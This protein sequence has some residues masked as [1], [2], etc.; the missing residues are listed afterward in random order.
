MS[1]LREKVETGVQVNEVQ[2]NGENEAEVKKL[3]LDELEKVSGGGA[4]L[5]DVGKVDPTDIDANTQKSM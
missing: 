2:T 5:H 3:D 4:S 1:D